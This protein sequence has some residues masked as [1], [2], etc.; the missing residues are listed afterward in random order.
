MIASQ[1][2]YLFYLTVR[3]LNWCSNKII[4]RPLISL[5]KLLPISEHRMERVKKENIYPIN[6]YSKTTNVLFA[7][8]LMMWTLSCLMTTIGLLIIHFSGKLNIENSFIIV[9]WSAV[10]LSIIINYLT[11]WKSN[12][13]E[14][15]FRKLKQKTRTKRDYVTAI[16]YHLTITTI[17]FL[18]AIYT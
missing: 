4:I 12:R 15:Y 5:L 3:I 11:L 17:C 9:L 14:S 10:L 16:L 1:Y 7:F 18:T 13:Y 2:N 8:N 6:S